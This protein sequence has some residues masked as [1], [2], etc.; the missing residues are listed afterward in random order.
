MD[1]NGEM[2]T[3]LIV[4]LLNPTETI[5]AVIHKTLVT[6]QEDDILYEQNIELGKVRGAIKKGQFNCRQY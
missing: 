4:E 3:T 1:S 6:Q 2:E 5:E